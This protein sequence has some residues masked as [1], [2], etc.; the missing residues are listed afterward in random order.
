MEQ[1]TDNPLLEFNDFLVER[2]SIDSIVTRLEFNPRGPLLF[3]SKYPTLLLELKSFTNC[4]SRD[5]EFRVNFKTEVLVW[6]VMR[7]TCRYEE[8][9]TY[10]IYT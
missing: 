3:G 6:E 5:F 1:E 8:K 10:L 9:V 7:S 2:L 4:I